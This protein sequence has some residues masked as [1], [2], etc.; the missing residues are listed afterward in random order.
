MKLLT[1]EILE[2]FKKIGNQKDKQLEDLE[3]VVKFFN[4]SGIG[5]WYATYYNSET[6]IFSGWVSLFNDHNDE[7]GDFSLKEL[8]EFKGA[9][10]LGIER[11]LYFGKGRTLK[12]VMN[13]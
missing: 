13:K 3:I 5:T 9:F 12:E 11:D 6:K 10:G 7:Y 4:P 8:E 1:K 2:R